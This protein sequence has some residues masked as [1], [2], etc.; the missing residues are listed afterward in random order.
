M[1]HERDHS[2][3]PG[4]GAVTPTAERLGADLDLT[5]RGITI[6]LLD[7]GFTAH[8]DVANRIVGFHAVE[9]PDATFP[10]SRPPHPWEWHGTQTT[11]VAAGDGALSDGIYRGLAPAARLLLVQVGREGSIHDAE[12]ARALEW[13]LA[14]F[15]RYGVRIVNI[16]LGGDVDAALPDS[17]VNQLAQE[18]VGRGL[19]VV[20]AAGN[21]GGRSEHRAVPPASAPSVITVG[22]YHDWSSPEGHA[23]AMYWSSFGDT[24]DGFAKPELIAPAIEVAAPI[25]VDAPEFQIAQALTRLAAAPDE[26]LAALAREIGSAADLPEEIAD[27]NLET[28]RAAVE[29]K[30]RERKIVAAHY[31]H[32]DGTSFA[33]PIV[34]SLAAQILEANPTLTPA[35]VKEILV[36]TAGR[37]EGAPA[38]RQGFGVIHAGRA[39]EAARKARPGRDLSRVAGPAP[40]VT[41]DQTAPRVESGKVIFLY[42]DSGASEVV[43]AGEFNGWEQAA[44]AREADGTWR[45]EIDVPPP[46]RYRYK[47]LIDGDRW[48]EDPGNAAREV[49][50]FG[51]F[52]SIL[53]V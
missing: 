46:G 1:D 31:Q 36:R 50:P 13:L 37:I 17:R 38:E 5:G 11:V 22:G 34:A 30:L 48:R 3:A 43:V 24:A 9:D 51:A 8:P 42:R 19:V 10:P 49:D 40:G 18:A 2:H 28:I 41:A 23:F 44:Y 26:A 20:A 4:P 29:T 15:E 12:I 25:P 21:S 16:S 7:A 45:V 53:S 6:A 33:A 35:E 32:V 52:D 39:V 47:L 27:G 14:N